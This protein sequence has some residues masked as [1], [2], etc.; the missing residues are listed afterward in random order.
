MRGLS[1][2]SQKQAPFPPYSHR[3]FFF[4]SSSAS[5]LTIP[6]T[7]N[8]DPN[9][10]NHDMHLHARARGSKFLNQIRF[11]IYIS[12]PKLQK[13]EGGRGGGRLSTEVVRGGERDVSVAG[14]Y[15][16]IEH[17][18]VWDPF[19]SNGPAVPCSLST[20]PFLCPPQSP[21]P[22]L[23]IYLP[24]VRHQYIYKPP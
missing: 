24:S 12:Y 5:S 2:C 16:G 13:R 23:F 1:P 10:T 15:L 3:P 9:R 8:F 14:D 7:I 11:F 22:P 19:G 6:F 18:V 17:K 20:I 21:S 4:N